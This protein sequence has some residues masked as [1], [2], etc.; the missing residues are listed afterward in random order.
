MSELHAG[1]RVSHDGRE[2]T[3]GDAGEGEDSGTV[4]VDWDS[5]GGGYGM[6]ADLERIEADVDDDD[7]G[8]PI[9]IDVG[10]PES[11]GPLADP[12]IRW[13]PYV[14]GEPAHIITPVQVDEP[15][16]DEYAWSNAALFG[17]ES[18][19]GAVRSPAEAEPEYVDVCCLTTQ[20]DPEWG[21]TAG[22]RGVVG[23]HPLRDGAIDA[24]R[25]ALRSK[26]KT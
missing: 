3:L 9:C 5:G 7:V 13:A 11:P 16:V 4:W 24:W 19:D 25:K 2:G 18:S 15:L 23:K 17:G 10:V 6:V 14:P 8:V 12:P 26:E 20:G 1:D 21:W 22:G